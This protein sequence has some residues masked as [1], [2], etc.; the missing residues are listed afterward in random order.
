M[1]IRKDDLELSM[2]P[3]GS[4]SIEAEITSGDEWTRGLHEQARINRNTKGSNVKQAWKDASRKFLFTWKEWS[5]FIALFVG[6]LADG[7][8][9][10]LIPYMQSAFGVSYTP[11]SLIFVV[12]MVGYIVATFTNNYLVDTLG[13]GIIL[14]SAMGLQAIGYALLSPA[15]NFP[16]LLI[17]NFFTGYGACISNSSAV[18]Y[19]GSRPNSAWKI[20]MIEA[21]YGLGGLV[22]PFVATLLIENG[23]KWSFFY[24]VEACVCAANAILFGI[25]FGL[26]VENSARDHGEHSREAGAEDHHAQ[27][28]KKI[29]QSK[30][31]WILALFVFLSVGAEVSISGWIASFL[32]KERGGTSSAGY[33]GTGFWGGMMLGSLFS[34]VLSVWLGGRKGVFYYLALSLALEFIIWFVPNL[35][36]NAVA[37]AFVGLAMGPLYP[38]ATNL[39][40]NRLPRALHTGTVTFM[41]ALGKTGGALFPFLT[42]ALAQRFSVNVLQP[43]M[44]IIFVLMVCVWAVAPTPRP[45]PKDEDNNQQSVQLES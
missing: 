17:L 23:A 8:A 36:G 21:F 38:N 37:V 45:L 41:A 4:R 18:A 7:S 6:G 12:Q 13:R 20:A 22:G 14:V 24:I 11:V 27:K 2:S 34:S 33:V 26:K 44:V 40:L 15:F 19:A 31:A 16:L 1:D 29:L 30:D 28:L 9:G 43:M 39:A 5:C 3:K 10:A 32:I 42:G 35:E 25:S